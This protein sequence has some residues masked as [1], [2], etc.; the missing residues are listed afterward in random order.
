MTTR[1]ENNVDFD[2][3]VFEKRNK[4]YGAYLLR[5]KYD[6][7][8]LS[9]LLIGVALMGSVVAIPYIASLFDPAKPVAQTDSGTPPHPTIITLE[10][11]IFE[12]EQPKTTSTGQLARAGGQSQTVASRTLVLSNTAN[13]PTQE[14]LNGV[15]PGLNTHPGDGDI[16]GG[17]GGEGGDCLDCPETGDGGGDMNKFT[18]FEVAPKYPGGDE[19]M[20][21]FLRKNI[22]YPERAKQLGVEGIVYIQFVVDEYGNIRF[23]KIARGIGGG[24]DEEAL[25]VV[26]MMPRWVP[27][28]QAGHSVRVQFHLPISYSL[29]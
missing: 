12:K 7:H 8:L 2:E 18:P 1:D 26:N 24:C 10:N 15:Q 19:A 23:A 11:V 17:G 27:A 25:R 5:K 21:E 28:K 20:Y 16:I 4:F 22:H 13:F 9:S 3:L 6:E 14:E 29:Q